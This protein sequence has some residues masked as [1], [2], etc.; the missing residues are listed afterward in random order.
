MFALECSY[1]SRPSLKY[2]NIDEAQEK[3]LNTTSMTMTEYLIEE[4]NT[5]LMERPK[6]TNN[7]KK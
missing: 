7:W 5:S 1:L 4:M 3:E 6:N 2:F